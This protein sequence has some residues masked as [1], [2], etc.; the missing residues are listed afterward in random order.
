MKKI[1]LTIITLSSLTL[2][3]SQTATDWGMPY[4][5]EKK[6][7]IIEE[8]VPQVGI[9]KAELYKRANDWITEYFT[10]GQKKIYERDPEQNFIK[11]KHRISVYKTVKKER[12]FDGVIEF[13]IDILLK[14]GKYKYSF[15]SFRQSPDA[16]SQPIEKWMDA[17]YT[18]P[19]E[20]ITRY[21]NLNSSMQ[22]IIDNLKKFMLTGKKE[23]DSS[24]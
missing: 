6:A 1:I 8:A 18:K 20:A 4:N 24:W 21:T 10:N 3:F 14:D 11:M 17:N 9:N 13:H 7:F 5:S 23:A 12:V 15:Y 22:E 16:N 2:G 19:E